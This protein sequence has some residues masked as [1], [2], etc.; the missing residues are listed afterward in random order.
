MC[1]RPV[2]T[3]VS[4]QWENAPLF[5]NGRVHKAAED[6]GGWLFSHGRRADPSRP[7]DEIPVVRVT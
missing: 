4:K 5:E 6:R 1:L 7:Y 3:A 2:A